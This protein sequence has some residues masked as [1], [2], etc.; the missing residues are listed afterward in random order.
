VRYKTLKA[1]IEWAKAVKQRDNY[2]CQVSGKKYRPGDRG[3]QAAH[4]FSRRYKTTRHDPDNGVTL[5]T[6]RHLW[7]HHFPLEFHEWVKTW[8]GVERY[9]A[10]KK[11]AMAIAY[12]GRM[13]QEVRS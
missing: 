13:P 7:A 1:D 5:D 10:L 4:I 12:G 9:E 3:I 11:K 6:R 8:M 2:T